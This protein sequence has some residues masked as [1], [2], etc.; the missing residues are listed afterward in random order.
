MKIL[1]YDWSQVR[2]F[3]RSTVPN[4]GD[5]KGIGFELDFGAIRKPYYD[6]QEHN[7]SEL[8]KIETP[9]GKNESD[10]GKLI[11]YLQWLYI[12]RTIRAGAIASFASK[13][14]SEYKKQDSFYFIIAEHGQMAAVAAEWTDGVSVPPIPMEKFS[15]NL[16]K[17]IQQLVINRN[18]TEP[19]EI[20]EKFLREE[21]GDFKQA[22]A[23]WD[24]LDF[25][26]LEKTVCDEFVKHYRSM[27]SV[28]SPV[29]GI[30]MEWYSDDETCLI[31]GGPFVYKQ[32]LGDVPIILPPTLEDL[33]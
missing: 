19:C 12:F 3:E 25:K 33:R 32:A 6:Y 22:V 14:F 31:E 15:P 23:N 21:G 20:L 4:T 2:D 9:L 28:D 13:E 10:R 1:N 27:K 26:K 18:I 8:Y 24:N 30:Y 17:N 7:N 16:Y 5:I 11:R 29:G